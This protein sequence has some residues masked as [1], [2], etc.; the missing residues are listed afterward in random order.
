MTI[1][2]ELTGLWTHIA[3]YRQCIIE[4]YNVTPSKFN[5]KRN[6]TK[7]RYQNCIKAE[8]H[9]YVSTIKVDSIIDPGRLRYLLA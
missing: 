3:V 9:F 4:L 7:K 6:K 1:E 8:L 2:G 5:E